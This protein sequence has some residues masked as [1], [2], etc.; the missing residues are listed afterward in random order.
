MGE[1]ELCSSI[2]W[3]TRNPSVDALTWHRL[4]WKKTIMM[5][6]VHALL[7][8]SLNKNKVYWEKKVA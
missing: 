2:L 7:Q 5:N 4:L 8:E 6:I 1:P 3:S